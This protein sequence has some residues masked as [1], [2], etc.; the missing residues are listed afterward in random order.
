MK[1]LAIL[2]ALFFAV[3]IAPLP[4]VALSPSE[5]VNGVVVQ[6]RNTIKE[7]EKKLPA[8]KLENELRG[9]ISPVFDFRTM[10]RSS[11]AA[12]WK[13]AK[14]EQQKE[15]V[16]LFSDLLAHTYLKR[17][18]DNAVTSD[19]EIL[20]EKRKGV[21]K[22]IVQTKVTYEKDQSATIDYRMRHK[23]DSW[24]VYD[25]IIEN[26]GLVSNYRQEFDDIVKKEKIDGLLAKLREKKADLD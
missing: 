23:D 18:R 4:A 3:L 7:K 15:F 24:L 26:I 10:A 13:D 6:V 9:I 17:I 2:I 25:V 1:K 20:G 16:D 19:F 14:P 8:A 12:H 5:T 22:A 11:L 21:K